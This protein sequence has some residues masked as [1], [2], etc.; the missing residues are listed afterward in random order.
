MVLPSAFYIHTLYVKFSPEKKK[1]F[2]KVNLKDYTKRTSKILRTKFHLKTK[3]APNWWLTITC[4]AVYFSMR[5]LKRGVILVRDCGP[6]LGISKYWEIRCCASSSGRIC[7]FLSLILKTTKSNNRSNILYTRIRYIT[8][9]RI[10]LHRYSKFLCS[11]IN[12]II[13]Q[14]SKHCLYYKHW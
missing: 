11:I 1:G 3:K 2:Q 10:I 6:L 8:W 9:L 7:H 12:K 4:L 5:A 14:N 13:L